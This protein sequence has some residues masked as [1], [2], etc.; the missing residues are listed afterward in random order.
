MVVFG[1]GADVDRADLLRGAA[2]PVVDIFVLQPGG[3]RLCAILVERDGIDAQWAHGGSRH[4]RGNGVSVRAVHMALGEKTL[5]CQLRKLNYGWDKI[6]SHLRHKS[7]ESA[8]I[9]G[10]LDAIGYADTAAKALSADA[11]GVLA[12]DLPEIDPLTKHA[13]MQDAIAAMEAMVVAED[14]KQSERASRRG[15]ERAQDVAEREALEELA[16]EAA[17]TKAAAKRKSSK[18]AAQGGITGDLMSFDVGEDIDV[19][20]HTSDS[21]GIVGRDVSIPNVAWRGELDDGRVA[22]CRVVGLASRA[23]A[24]AT[25]G[26]HYTFTVANMRIYLQSANNAE[27]LQ[28]LGGVAAVKGAPTSQAIGTRAKRK[29]VSRRAST[30]AKRLVLMS[31]LLLGLVC[32]GQTV[33]PS[34]SEDAMDDD[35]RGR[36]LAPHG[37]AEL[38]AT[39]HEWAA[40]DRAP[41][42]ASPQLWERR[43]M[44]EVDPSDSGP[45]ATI[46]QHVRQQDV[47]AHRVQ[48]GLAQSPEPRSRRRPG[49]AVAAGHTPNLD[50]L[51]YWNEQH[52]V[53]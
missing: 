16:A 13:G 34:G 9:Y 31:T 43:A 10:R 41:V 3:C 47:A 14:D 30:P 2:A 51:Q 17:A 21:W 25:G 15:H 45:P 52:P 20:A 49:W 11:S 50:T 19:E 18:Q 4:Y 27:L 33:D 24:V 44:V 23:Y 26:F 40:R 35:L 29:P 32:G 53:V 6:T 8:R 28:D 48:A 7:A 22:V 37:D 1:R 5:A 42:A 38:L 36:P 12:A 39:L 46:E